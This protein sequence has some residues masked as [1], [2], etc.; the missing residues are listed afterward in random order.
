MFKKKLF[1]V[2]PLSKIFSMFFPKY[3]YCRVF[4]TARKF[5]FWTI[6]RETPADFIKNIFQNSSDPRTP[7][8]FHFLFHSEKIICHRPAKPP[9]IWFLIL[10][11][12]NN[13]S[14]TREPPANPPRVSFLISLWKNNL[15]QTRKSPAVVAFDFTLKKSFVTDPR[16]PRGFQ[17]WLYFEK[18][19]CHRPAKLP[20]ILILT[21]LWKN[22][23]S[24]RHRPAD[25]IFDFTLKK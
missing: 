15:S 5:Q 14:Q 4:Q 12:K 20:Q 8:G 25:F 16:N 1:D 3:P 22:N 18:I 2:S 19:I 21:L 7:R 13:L 9:R 17:F 24:Q 10:L 11:W 6:P 23:L